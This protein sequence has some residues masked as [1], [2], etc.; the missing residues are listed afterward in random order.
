M[1][2]GRQAS[3]DRLL[4]KWPILGETPKKGVLLPEEPVFNS[5]SREIGRVDRVPSSGFVAVRMV[6]HCAPRAAIHI[7]GFNWSPKNWEGH[8]MD[9]E[10]QIMLD[11]AEEKAVTIHSTPC[12]GLRECGEQGD[13]NNSCH[14]SVTHRWMC[15][16]DG[17]WRDS[18][19]FLDMER[20]LKHDKDRIMQVEALLKRIHVKGLTEVLRRR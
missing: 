7:Y 15:F 18:T 8:Q 6:Q 5:L 10:K 3:A 17:N 19:N 2:G 16:R 4:Q 13:V 14:W 20:R 12:T 9:G 1:L 11:M